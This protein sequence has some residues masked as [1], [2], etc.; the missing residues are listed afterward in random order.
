MAIHVESPSL[1][2]GSGTPACHGIN[3]M[4]VSMK[5]VSRE[6]FDKL[7]P[8]WKCK[9][10]QKHLAKYDQWKTTNEDIAGATMTTGAAEGFSSLL[11]ST[12]K[13]KRSLRNILKRSPQL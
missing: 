7:K 4:R 13:K 6:K 9:K 2:Q 5:A 11:G 10:C 12:T 8:D 3:L 1:K